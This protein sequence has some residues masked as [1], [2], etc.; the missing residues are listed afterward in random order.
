MEPKKSLM[1]MLLAAVGAARRCA[2]GDTVV[3]CGVWCGTLVQNP[4]KESDS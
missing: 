4:W 2:S 3:A 1:T